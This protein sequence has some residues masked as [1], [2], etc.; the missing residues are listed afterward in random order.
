MEIVLKPI[1]R[2]KVITLM[3]QQKQIEAQINELVTIVVE[4]E[5]VVLTQST[6]VMF[7]DDLS[8]LIIEDVIA[9]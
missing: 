4:C 7:S 8:K 2:N 6:K 5:D 9:E 1:M 3:Q